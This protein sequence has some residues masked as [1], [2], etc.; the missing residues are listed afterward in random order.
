MRDGGPGKAAHCV[1]GGPQGRDCV[2]RKA[3][4]VG[5]SSASLAAFGQTVT[6]G[7]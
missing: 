1:T 3:A 6:E 2:N 4:S 7:G 5:P